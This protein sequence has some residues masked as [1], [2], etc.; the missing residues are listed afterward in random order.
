VQALAYSPLANRDLNKSLMDAG[1]SCWR[2]RVRPSHCDASVVEVRC[3]SHW[4]WQLI[5][6]DSNWPTSKCIP[7]MSRNSKGECPQ[8][9]GQQLSRTRPHSHLSKDALANGRRVSHGSDVLVGAVHTAKH[10]L[11]ACLL[12][13]QANLKQPPGAC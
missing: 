4:L 6:F 8:Q 2:S 3:F 12:T 10:A 9:K 5:L 13:L 11:A 7:G 1:H